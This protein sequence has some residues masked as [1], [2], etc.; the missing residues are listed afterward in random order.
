MSVVLLVIRPVFT[1]W[2]RG[3]VNLSIAPSLSAM[4]RWRSYR[5]VLRQSLGFFQNDYAGRISQKVMQ[6]GMALRESVVN[7][8]DGVWYL[9]VYLVGTAAVLI[10]FDWRLLLPILVWLVAYGFVIVTL[11]PPVRERSIAMSEANSGL[12]G[13]VVDG[14]TNI[15]SVKLFA[16][17]EREEAFGRVAFER[18]LA[19]RA[20]HEPQ[21]HDADRG[22]RRC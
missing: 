19:R 21:H 2:S 14:F 1:I 13:R 9:L 17:A 5:Y 8:I 6:T 15:L 18:Q 10:G 22:A 11:V 16:H 12:T 7:V 20:R 4:V 3:L